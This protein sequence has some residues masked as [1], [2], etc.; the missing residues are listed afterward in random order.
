M[1]VGGLLA[2]VA[3]YLKTLMPS[4]R[5]IG[6]EREA[7]P[8]ILHREPEATRH[9]A[10]AEACEVAVDE[11]AR[12]AIAIDGGEVDGVRPARH[13]LEACGVCGV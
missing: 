4:V 6:V 2:G 9:D 5:V 7:R 11:A 13:R 8:A 3:A 12:V 1:A 10:G